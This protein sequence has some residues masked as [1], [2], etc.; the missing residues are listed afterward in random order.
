MTERLLPLGL[1]GIRR[2]AVLAGGHSGER[3]VSL[4]S[5]QAVGAALAGAGLDVCSLD[6]IEPGFVGRL[7]AAQVDCVFN[8]LHGPGGEDGTIQGLL[9]SMKLPYTGSGVLGSALSMD[10][11]RSKLLCQ[12]MALPVPPGVICPADRPAEPPFPLPWCVK[13]VDQGSSLGVSRVDDPSGLE[14]AFVQARRH[15]PRILIEPWI[16]GGEYTV[17][18]VASLILPSIRIETARGFYDYE[19]KYKDPKTR[20]HC[21]SGLDPGREAA[22]GDLARRAASCLDVSGW[23]RVDFRI[24]PDHRPYLIEVNT[25]PGMTGHSLVP[26][27]AR[28]HGWDFT[29]LCLEILAQCRGRGGRT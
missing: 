21:P 18:L 6:P 1:D 20:Y 29:R 17:A 15:S 24:T 25:V 14:A 23:C 19:A 10:K 16:E 7:L 5:G 26:M 11:Y 13:P 22:L 9:E 3:A 4:E 28:A 12:T 27:A 2:V 8:V